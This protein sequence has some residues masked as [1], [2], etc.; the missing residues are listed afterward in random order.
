MDHETALLFFL[1]NLFC[2][3]HA[4]A[5]K[6]KSTLQQLSFDRS[7]LVNFVLSKK[8]QEVFCC[9]PNITSDQVL[10]ILSK[11]SLRKATDI[12]GIKSRVLRVA[13]PVIAA[14]IAKLI[15]CSIATGIYPQ[16][17]KTAK[18]TPPYKSGNVDDLFNY[19]SISVLPILSKVIE[20]RL[21]FTSFATSPQPTL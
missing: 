13:A 15:S 4:E 5:Y 1:R 17:W 18:V 9:T 3:F 11:I 12:D 19:R 6:L 16:R 10:N 21:I 8:N 14:T 20:K 2:T 7:K